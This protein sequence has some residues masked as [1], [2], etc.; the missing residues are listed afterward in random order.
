MLC[1]EDYHTDSVVAIPDFVFHELHM[2]KE[3]YPQHAM[4]RLWEWVHEFGE[5]KSS[6]YISLKT[7]FPHANSAV[8]DYIQQDE[9]MKC[10]FK[11]INSAAPDNSYDRALIVTAGMV[12]ESLES[13]ILTLNSIDFNTLVKDRIS[14]YRIKICS[15]QEL[16]DLLAKKGVKLPT[17]RV[18]LRMAN[19]TEALAYLELSP[20]QKA[21]MPALEDK[22]H[23]DPRQVADALGIPFEKVDTKLRGL[24]YN[25]LLRKTNG[26]YEL[27]ELGKEV[28]AALKAKQEDKENVCLKA[29]T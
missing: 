17:K 21:I 25:N 7:P 8:E 19:T 15:P 10:L 2:I 9:D 5:R 26:T 20:T 24:A 23:I 12:H 1:W 29:I 4:A 18:N 22:T 13:T 28:I 11:A 27:T 3:K 14:D 16:A 6:L